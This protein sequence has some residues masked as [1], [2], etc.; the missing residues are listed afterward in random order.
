M[1]GSLLV[2]CANLKL[3]FLLP[4]KNALH[5]R[6]DNEVLR[7][8]NRSLGGGRHFVLLQGGVEIYTLHSVLPIFILAL[9]KVNI[10]MNVFFV[11][12]TCFFDYLEGTMLRSFGTSIKMFWR[13][14]RR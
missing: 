10:L 1:K 7:T 13:F 8:T 4:S 9:K 2:Y 11:C 3:S 5:W 12:L 6:I 14:A